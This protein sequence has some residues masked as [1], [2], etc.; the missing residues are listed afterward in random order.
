MSL[1]YH[2]FFK[3]N[4]IQLAIYWRAH[5]GGKGS[6]IKFIVSLT[7]GCGVVAYVSTTL[8][9]RQFFNITVFGPRVLNHPPALLVNA[10][11]ITQWYHVFPMVKFVSVNS[12]GDRPGPINPICLQKI[13]VS[14]YLSEKMFMAAAHV[15][16]FYH[17]QNVNGPYAGGNKVWGIVC[18]SDRCW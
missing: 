2:L 6:L 13:D 12:L 4:L 8:I 10:K 3:F 5:G 14:V 1:T 11:R 9:N 15:T 17:P 18:T 16:L 7:F